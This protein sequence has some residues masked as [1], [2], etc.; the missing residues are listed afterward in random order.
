[1]PRSPARIVTELFA[2]REARDMEGMFELLDPAVVVKTANGRSLEFEGHEGVFEYFR[3]T[4]DGDRFVE[5]PISELI[6]LGDGRILAIGRLRVHE[7]GLGVSDSSGVWTV[8]VRDGL[9]VRIE[10]YRSKHEALAASDPP[11]GG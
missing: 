6:D 7:R 4:A 8:E 9:V 5:T 11:R 3:G 1:M 2:R 10:S